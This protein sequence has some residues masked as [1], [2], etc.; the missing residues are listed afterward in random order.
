MSR[1]LGLSG[2]AALGLTAL[3][4]GSPGSSSPETAG[5]VSETT[6]RIRDRDIEFFEA[7]VAADPAGAL[8]RLRLGVLNLERARATGKEADLHQA[9][10]LARASLSLREAHNSGAWHLLAAALLGQHRFVE[11]LWAAER[12]E[13]A[14][15]AA[16]PRA[17][18]GEILL[19]LGRYPEADSVL[20]SL[21]AFR[22]Q[23]GITPRYARWLELRGRS[24]EARRLLEAGRRNAIERGVPDELV[25]YD[26]RLGDLNLRHGRY[27]EARR[28]LDEG[29]GLRPD[30]W[31]L[32]AGRAR[33][34][35]KEGDGRL[36]VALGDSSLALHFDPATLALVADGWRLENQPE[37]AEPYLRALEAAGSSAP[38]GGFH[39]SW[40][41]ALL[42]HDRM[43]PLVL[44]RVAQ[45]L[46]TRPDAQGWDLLAWALFKSGRLA[47]ARGASTIAL[48]LGTGDPDIER[49]ARII[50]DSP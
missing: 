33:L 15:P 26:L 21:S 25:W 18:R 10:S 1:R 39:R 27:R 42:D 9:E 50:E 45:D 13:Q 14:D 17:L 12:L 5:S 23:P 8:D 37:L 49:H 6:A 34:A 16:G 46:T 47:E 19:E 20:G 22:H 7:R 32:L 29:L 41:L 24:A 36:A 31:R 2:L 43:V 28:L 35:L 48:T 44:S 3:L 11:A 38:R 4:S 30:D 40:Y